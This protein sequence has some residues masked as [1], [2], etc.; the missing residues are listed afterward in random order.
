MKSLKSCLT[1]IIMLAVILAPTPGF[2]AK[3][4]VFSYTGEAQKLKDLGLYN[5]VSTDTFN[6]DLG[7]ALDR[8][9]GVV[10][11]LRIFGLEADA[12]A[13]TDADTILAKFTDASTIADWAKK[14][15]AYAV[16]NGLVKGTTDT[17]FAPS[18]SLEGKAYCTLILRQLGFTDAAYDI[19]PVTLAEK[20][21]LTADEATRFTTKELIKDDLVGISFGTLKATDKDGKKVIDTLIADKKIDEAGAVDSGLITIVPSPTT[22]PPISPEVHH[23]SSAPDITISGLSNTQVNLGHNSFPFT[24]SLADATIN[25]TNSSPTII[26]NVSTTTG[27]TLRLE[28]D[29]ITKGTATVTVTATKSGYNA[30]S[31]QIVITVGDIVPPTVLVSAARSSIAANT[32]DPLTERSIFITFSEPINEASKTVI[33]SSILAKLFDEYHFL[34]SDALIMFEWNDTNTVLQVWK[35][36]NVEAFF[37]SKVTANITDLA[38]NTTNNAILVDI[39]DAIPGFSVNVEIATDK[40]TINLPPSQTNVATYKYLLS[41]T[42]IIKPLTGEAFNRDAQTCVQGTELS[43]NDMGKW[44]G[45]FALDAQNRVIGFSQVKLDT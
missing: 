3:S 45:V 39:P 34:V 38:D 26:T 30:A 14:Q 7:T 16:K 31:Q 6:P 40:I 9:T 28:F 44:L 43:F 25:V 24:V 37:D 4:S 2:A 1:V 20:G 41:S 12:L 32:E 42:N 15:V 29:A 5:G 8:Q 18:A 10:M 22:I 36:D 21:G 35:P 11:L 19:A 13:L 27:D 23:H 17:S 33:R